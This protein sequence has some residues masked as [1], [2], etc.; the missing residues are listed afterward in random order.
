MW[1]GT[2]QLVGGENRTKRWRKGEFP[3]S[4]SRDI[5]FLL[6]SDTGAPGPPTWTGTCT[7]GSPGAHAFGFVLQLHRQRSW[8]SGVQSR[9][10]D[11][12]A[13]TDA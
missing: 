5:H 3:L 7:I 2:M 13:P 12:S 11:F 9:P 1:V 8:A 6:A 10:W 4:L